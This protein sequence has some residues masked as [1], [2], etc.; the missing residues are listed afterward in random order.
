ML[1]PNMPNFND[2][3]RCIFWCRSIKP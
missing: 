1:H 3:I 2:S